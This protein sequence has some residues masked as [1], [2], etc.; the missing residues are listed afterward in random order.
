MQETA[1]AMPEA[2]KAATLEDVWVV[3][4]EIAEQ[5]KESKA[6]YDRK[7]AEYARIAAARDLAIERMSAKVEELSANV[8]GINNSLGDMAE[9]L[10]ASDLYEKFETRGLEFDHAFPNYTVKDKKTKL[11]LTEVDLLMV[12]G[13]IAMAVEVKTTMTRGDVDKHETRMDILRREPN[14][15]F[16]NRVLYGAMAGVKMSDEAREY[17]IEKGFFVIDLTGN[18]VKIDVPTDFTPKT[19]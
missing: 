14:S 9:G 18:M 12:N 1:A 11:K 4:R 17:A 5:H 16:I 2:R 10:M 7:S 3:I 13:T 19:W 15:L 6:E 8:G